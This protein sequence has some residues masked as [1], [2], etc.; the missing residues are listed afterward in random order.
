MPMR[1][2]GARMRALRRRRRVKDFLVA[3]EHPAPKT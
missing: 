2:S 1:R 3:D